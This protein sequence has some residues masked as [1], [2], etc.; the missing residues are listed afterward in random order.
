MSY[1]IITE[2]HNGEISCNS[3]IGEGTEF[4]ITIPVKQQVGNG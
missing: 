4:I 3:K 1:Q 2:K